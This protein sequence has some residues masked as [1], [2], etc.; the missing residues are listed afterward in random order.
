MTSPRRWLPFVA[1]LLLGSCKTAENLVYEPKPTDPLDG[2][3]NLKEAGIS[4]G[5]DWGPKQN[6]LLSDFK[7]LK[8]EHA[9]LQKS[10]E[11]AQAECLNL[12]TQLNNEMETSRR[13]KTQRAQS[14]AALEQKNQ[15]I[16][17]QEVTILGLRIEKAKLEQANL[18][19]R[20]EAL[21]AAADQSAPNAVEAAATPPGRR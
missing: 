11:R 19:A 13:E 8:E 17:E 16:R 14:D 15:K 4:T 6:F 7:T 21:R 10:Y 18:L 20:M 9:R 3:S 2:Y 5:M 12:K 1:M